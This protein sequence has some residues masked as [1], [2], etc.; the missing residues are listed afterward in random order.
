MSEGAGYSQ[1]VPTIQ[2]RRAHLRLAC[3]ELEAALA[4]PPDGRPDDW[5]RQVASGVVRMRHA[6]A[7]HVSITEG[8]DG[9]FDQIRTEAPRL[10]GALRRLHREHGDL[11]AQLAAIGAHL[12]TPDE[13]GLQRARDQLNTTLAELSRHLQRGADLLYQAYDIDIGGE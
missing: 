8:P 2:G 1:Q 9:L 6:F 12:E 3:Q 7:A 4:A 13:V 5:A 11:A 10:D